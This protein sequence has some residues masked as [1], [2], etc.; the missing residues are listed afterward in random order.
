MKV[1]YGSNVNKKHFLLSFIENTSKSHLIGE[2][3]LHTKFNYNTCHTI[4]STRLVLTGIR[5]AIEAPPRYNK[6]KVLNFKAGKKEIKYLTKIPFQR[7][8]QKKK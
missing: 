1:F 3:I 8:L 6:T 7:G 2:I 4:E 5:A